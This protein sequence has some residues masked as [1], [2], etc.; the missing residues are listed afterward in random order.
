MIE[1]MHGSWKGRGWKIEKVLPAQ[2][3]ST[4]SVSLKEPLREQKTLCPR[5]QEDVAFKCIQADVAVTWS[6]RYWL[7]QFSYLLHKNKK[8]CIIFHWR[9]CVDLYARKSLSMVGE[10]L[11]RY[12]FI[13]FPSTL[14]TTLFT[15]DQTAMGSFVYAIPTG[16][17]RIRDGVR[18]PSEW[19]AKVSG[20]QRNFSRPLADCQTNLHTNSRIWQAKRKIELL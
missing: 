6:T 2:R 8:K 15:G 13:Q 10:R 18:R 5:V 19:V 16:F 9:L 20:L 1:K 7:T 17:D 3:D 11:R 12:E 14:S 4:L